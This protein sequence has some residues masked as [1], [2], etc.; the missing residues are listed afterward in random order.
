M[1]VPLYNVEL[2]SDLISGFVAVKLS[3][4]VKVVSLIFFRETI[5]LEVVPLHVLCKKGSKSSVEDVSNPT[6][7][8]LSETF[9]GDPDFP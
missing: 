4:P 3:L 8:D 9:M 2:E 6:M 7:I 1:E 5:W